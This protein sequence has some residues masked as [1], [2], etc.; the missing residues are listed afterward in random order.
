MDFHYY[1]GLH[2]R[3]KTHFCWCGPYSSIQMD[4]LTDLRRFQ[5]KRVAQACF[6]I[7]HAGQVY[8]EGAAAK[9]S[10]SDMSSAIY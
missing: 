2:H 3:K 7:F 9:A 8:S 1:L 5:K 10:Q 6:L 4:A